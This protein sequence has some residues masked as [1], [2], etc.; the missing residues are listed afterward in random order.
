MVL[1]ELLLFYARS[2]LWHAFYSP[3]IIAPVRKYLITSS[4]LFYTNA[5]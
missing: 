4:V 3:V 5:L 1:I 2:D